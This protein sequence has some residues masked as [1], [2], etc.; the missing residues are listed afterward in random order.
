MV[1]FL[2]NFVVEGF[3]ATCIGMIFAFG[4]AYILK[5]YR[6]LSK[7]P[8]GC[9]LIF[10]MATIS[11]LFAEYNKK[12]GIIAT[13]ACG[14]IMSNYAWYNLSPQAQQSSKV[15]FK[16]L[17]HLVEGFVF[18][19]I[20]LTFTLYRQ[21]SYSKSLIIFLFFTTIITKAIGTFGV[22]YLSR[23]LLKEK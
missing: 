6:S 3:F 14:M 17:G 5:R 1:R 11:Y 13:L 18:T 10:C 20:G 8:I 19:Y 7:S 23:W 16:T 12:S 2:I 9:A 22:F 15:I 21:F 4:C